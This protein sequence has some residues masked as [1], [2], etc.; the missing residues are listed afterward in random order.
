MGILRPSLDE[1]SF[2][3]MGNKISGP[4]AL[5]MMLLSCV[6]SMV[7]VLK[8]YKIDLELTIYAV[9]Q[10]SANGGQSYSM[11]VCFIMGKRF[12]EMFVYLTN[13]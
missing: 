9:L 11:I 5:M 8:F 13:L 1:F 6:S 2:V 7:F 4:F 3:K 12:D 10:V